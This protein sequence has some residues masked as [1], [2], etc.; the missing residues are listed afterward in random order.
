MDASSEY[1]SKWMCGHR[2]GY[3]AEK[4]LV[5]LTLPS[6][7]AICTPRRQFS[8]VAPSEYS[9]TEARPDVTAHDPALLEHLRTIESVARVGPGRLFGD[10]GQARCRSRRR[11]RSSAAVPAA[12]RQSHF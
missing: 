6:A 12:R 10:L 5:I 9:V 2:Q 8:S 7:S 3:A 11:G 4:M 1:T